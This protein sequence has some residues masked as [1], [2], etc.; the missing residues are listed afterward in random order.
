MRLDQQFFIAETNG[1]HLEPASDH[2]QVSKN[3]AIAVTLTPLRLGL[4]EFMTGKMQKHG[5]K[6]RHFDGKICHR[7]ARSSELL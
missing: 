1:K 7:R 2:A 3:C 4:S 6:S 5:L